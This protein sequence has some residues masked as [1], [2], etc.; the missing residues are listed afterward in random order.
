MKVWVNRPGREYQEVNVPAKLVSHSSDGIQFKFSK[1]DTHYRVTVSP[2]E[3]TEGYNFFK[4]CS[5][6]D[7]LRRQA[8]AHWLIGKAVRITNLQGI[9]TDLR[10]GCTSAE[11]TSVAIAMWSTSKWTRP[12]MCCSMS[13]WRLRDKKSGWPARTSIPNCLLGRRPKL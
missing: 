3:L 1:G 5:E 8:E 2:E 12:A 4:Q 11:S 6:E 9:S 10:L 7:R 13:N